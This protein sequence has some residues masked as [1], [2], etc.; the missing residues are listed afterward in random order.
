VAVALGFF[1]EK[2]G[3]DHDNWFTNLMQAQAYERAL[4]EDGSVGNLLK[5]VYIQYEAPIRAVCAWI[6]WLGIMIVYSIYGVNW[7]YVQAQYFA[8]STLSTGGHWGT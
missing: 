8:I 2:I 6:I 4:K 5:Q 1:A 7:P 3:E